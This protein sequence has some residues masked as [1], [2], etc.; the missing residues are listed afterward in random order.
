MQKV[1]QK[2]MQQQVA[3]MNK[4][5]ISEGLSRKALEHL[6]QPVLS[7]DEFESKISDKRC[8]VVGFYCGDADP[9]RDLSYFIDRSS[10]PIL[11]TEVSP[12]PTPDGYYVVWVEIQRD[13][14]FPQ[15]LLDVLSE[16]DNLS[17]V[18]QWQFQC[19]GHK[20]PENLT[21]ESLEKQIVLDQSQIPDTTDDDVDQGPDEEEPAPEPHDSDE[22]EPND[23]NILKEFWQSANVDYVIV[24][25][26]SLTLQRYGS[27]YT[28]HM[29]VDIPENVALLSESSDARHLQRLVGPK[30]AVY[31]TPTGF[32]VENEE[33]SLFLSPVS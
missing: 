2:K 29:S 30:Y 20:D 8:I 7:I 9:A 10:Q 22:D 33:L 14:H 26:N 23:T 11:D 24:E 18:K 15:V 17:T 5:K 21:K 32:V 27:S 1:P 12:A 3:V 25:N 28:Y 16:V 4:S 19:P 13:S 6:V 31:A